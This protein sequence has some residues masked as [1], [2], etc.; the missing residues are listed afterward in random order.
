MK[1]QLL[2]FLVINL[3]PIH[4]FT[5]NIEKNW[6]KKQLSQLDK[7]KIYSLSN[8]YGYIRYYYPNNNLKNFDWYKFLVYS[9]SELN[10]CVDEK[11]ISEKLYTL[12]HPLCPQI[13]FNNNI[14]KNSTPKTNSFYICKN[15]N[16]HDGI[17]SEIQHINLWE[18]KYP[19]P[20][21]LYNFSIGENMIISFPVAISILPQPGKDYQKLK[22]KIKNIKLNLFSTS[23]LK[24]ALGKKTQISFIKEL[25]CRIANEIIRCNIIK[26]FYPYSTEDNL[27][28]SWN[29]SCENHWEKVA[30]CKNLQEYYLSVC[31]FMHTIKDS[32]V[33]INFSLAIG[34]TA[35][36]SPPYYPALEVEILNNKTL[37]IHSSNPLLKGYNITKINDIP[38]AVV[39]N[40]KMKNISYS[41]HKAGI[42]KLSSNYLFKSFKKD[43]VI[44]LTLQKNEQFITYNIKTDLSSPYIVDTTNFIE[45]VDSIAYINLTSEKGEYNIFKNKIQEIKNTKGIIFDMRGYVQ[46]YTLSIL[47]NIIK[48]KVSLGNLTKPISFFPGQL[49]YIPVNKWSIYPA[50]SKDSEKKAIENE[51]ETPIGINIQQ[52][53]VFLMDYTSMSFTET[54]LDIIKTY[55]LGTIVGENSAGCNGDIMFIKLPFASF[56]ISGYKF[57]NRDF[58]QHHGKGIVPDIYVINNYNH[59]EQLKIAKKILYEKLGTCIIK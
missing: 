44:Q 46:P 40:Q 39:L 48:S 57:I 25:N 14:S 29:K 31:Q 56:T 37:I 52:P 49:E 15:E 30:S 53:C 51:Y 10:D 5:K 6:E 35:I 38:I 17:Y 1:Y 21:S 34:K 20:D 43:S 12:F 19:T 11:H 55:K 23:L 36:Y 54:L 27:L 3:F 4:C 58:S 2:I 7:L 41:H 22:S 9:L 8:L 45:F 18:N 26:L 32:H 59:D 13:L 16:R 33:D 28:I 47:S 50:I 24:A 42:K